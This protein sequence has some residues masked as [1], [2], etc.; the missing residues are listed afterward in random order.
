M[1][2]MVTYEV[3]AVLEENLVYV[4][5]GM[6]ATMRVLIGERDDVL[7]IPAAAIQYNRSREPV[8]SVQIADGEWQEQPVQLGM[9]DGI[10]VEVISGLKEGQTV[11][12]PIFSPWTP[13]QGGMPP[14]VMEEMP[15]PVQSSEE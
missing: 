13:D 3:E 2:G 5:P 15:T 14:E 9:N 11:V 8:V 1:D 6:M 12:M 4:L 7:A 10:M